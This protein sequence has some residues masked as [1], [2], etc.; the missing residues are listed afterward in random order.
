M[1]EIIVALDYPDA[2]SALELV[3]RLEGEADYFKVGLEL[4]VREGP[5]VVEELRVRGN[6]VFLDLKLHDIPNTVASAVRSAGA[7]GV[8]LL[9]VHLGGGESMLRAAAEAAESVPEAGWTP[10]RL[11]GVTVLTSLHVTEVEAT[12]GR[13]INALRDEVLRLAELGHQCGLRGLVASA[14]EA[15]D[16]RRR[17]GPDTLLVIPGIRPAGADTHD[18][19]RVATPAV[20]AEAGADCLVVGRSITRADDPLRAFRLI[21]AEAGR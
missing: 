10:V 18:Q 12:W 19:E 3:D 20:A 4:F 13:E 1:P 14:W 15:E 8:D 5:S 6:R 21:R 9:T 16:L 7:L 17:F 2:R 11:L